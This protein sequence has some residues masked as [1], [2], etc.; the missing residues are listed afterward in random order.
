M[1]SLNIENLCFRLRDSQL[2]AQT[3]DHGVDFLSGY[4]SWLQSEVLPGQRHD[5]GHGGQATHDQQCFIAP[6]QSLHLAESYGQRIQVRRNLS[7]QCSKNE[8]LFIALL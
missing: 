1:G 7:E 4:P 3:A 8:D 6:K 5:K 2:S